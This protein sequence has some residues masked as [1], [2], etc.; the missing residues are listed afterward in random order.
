MMAGGAQKDNIHNIILIFKRLAAVVTGFV[1]KLIINN[2]VPV[3][4][5][6]MY[7]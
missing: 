4:S 6:P 3:G 2:T 1:K 5:L 7:A